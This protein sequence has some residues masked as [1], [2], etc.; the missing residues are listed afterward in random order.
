MHR[1]N[2]EFIPHFQIICIPTFYSVSKYFVYNLI[3]FKRKKVKTCQRK[4][5]RQLQIRQI[6]EEKE[7]IKVA[8]LAKFVSVTPENYVKI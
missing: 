7:K 6:L 4:K 8:E 3:G 5:K 1:N 2:I